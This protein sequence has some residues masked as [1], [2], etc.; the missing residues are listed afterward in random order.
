MIKNKKKMIGASVLIAAFAYGL[1][2]TGISPVLGLLN[3]KYTSYGTSMVQLLQTIPYLLIIVGSLNVGWLTTKI[4]K[5]RIELLAMGIIGMCGII[6]FFT[7]SF[8]AI[9]ISR[10]LIGYGFGLM[11]PMNT[12]IVTEFLPAEEMAPYLG[13]NVV[14]M[15][16]GT[17]V[18]NLIGG[19]LAGFGYRYFFLVYVI[20]FIGMIGI[21]LVLTETAPV[22]AESYSNAKLNNMIFILAFVSLMHSL[23]INAYNTNIGIYI[24]KNITEN[25]SATGVVTAFNAAFALMVGL[26]FGRIF[27]LL[28]RF[29]L[30]FSVLAAVAGYGAVLLI[31]GMA[32]VYT[33]SAL[34]GIS[35][36]CFMA[37]SSYL[38]SVSVEQEA[39]AKAAGVFS[40][41]GGIG[42]LIAPVVLGNS[43]RVLGG[44]SAENQF[45]V[46]LLGMLVLTIIV[47]I[48]T[49]KPKKE[50]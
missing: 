48:I 19:F 40:I 41:A 39:V 20:A 14:G 15:G 50:D 5:K 35:L 49:M 25:P 43:A 42:G 26:L 11:G 29:T 18:G 12:A 30:P 2:I 36:S 46:A 34:C 44:N 7:E 38:I 1:N 9:M 27:G 33:A 23:F 13:L 47:T 24:L 37:I 17:M 21:R 4:S 22:A 10:F 16:I 8:P 28:K 3:E 31:P 32:G 45:I 6:P